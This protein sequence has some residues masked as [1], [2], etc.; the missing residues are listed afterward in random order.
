MI[1][2]HEASEARMGRVPFGHPSAARSCMTCIATRPANDGN[3]MQGLRAHSAS[4]APLSQQRSRNGSRRGDPSKR[5]NER[6][7]WAACACKRRWVRSSGAGDRVGQDAWQQLAL[8]ATTHGRERSGMP[9]E[10][11]AEACRLQAEFGE[12]WIHAAL[13]WHTILSA[14]TT[15]DSIRKG[16]RS[17]HTTAAVTVEL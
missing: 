5:L 12:K 4:V 11:S 15:V 13:L 9:R 2:W 17:M 10:R 6:W 7:R 8:C 1:D 14:Q 3:G 16:N